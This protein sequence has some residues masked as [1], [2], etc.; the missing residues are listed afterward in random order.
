M[1]Q[2]A[3]SPTIQALV[4]DRNS[5]FPIDWMGQFY[6][7]IWN[8]N[9][10]AGVGLNIWGGIV[11]VSRTINVPAGTPNPGMFPFVSGVYQMTDAEYRRVIM[12]KAL[13]NITVSSAPNL[14][15]LMSTLFADRG[16]CYVNDYGSMTMRFTAEFYIYPFEYV[17]ITQSESSPRP[18][19]VLLTIFQID[20][21]QTFGF[22]EGVQYQPFDQGVFY[23]G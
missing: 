7:V 2:Y 5:Y 14:N 6:D 17:I 20:P 15:R 8:I 16:R 4:T 22:S 1:R 13:A 9:T 18:A 10:A 21:R 11:G 23:G 3:A 19:G 12:T